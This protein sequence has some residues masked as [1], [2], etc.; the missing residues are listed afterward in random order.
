MNNVPYE[1]SVGLMLIRGAGADNMSGGAGNDTYVVDNT[2]DVVSEA[3]GEGT[4][5][6]KSVVKGKREDKDGKR[7][8]RTRITTIEGALDAVRSV[9]RGNADVKRL[10]GVSVAAN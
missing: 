6:R 1:N 8:T 9:I 2:G 10:D 7:L 3:A 4:E 5:D